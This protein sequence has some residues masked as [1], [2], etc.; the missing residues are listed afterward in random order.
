MTTMDHHDA[1]GPEEA[2][3]NLPPVVPTGPASRRPAARVWQ[4]GVSDCP[5]AED[6]GQLAKA[7]PGLC[8]RL[9][10]GPAYDAN[11]T[12]G[13]ASFAG[14][15]GATSLELRERPVQSAR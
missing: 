7:E 5:T 15:I 8:R 13:T 12:A 2:L 9:E 14:A 10:I 3:Y 4:A 6:S 1:E 11:T